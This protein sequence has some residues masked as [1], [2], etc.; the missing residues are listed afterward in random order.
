[1]AKEKIPLVSV[2]IPMYNAERFISQT[3]ESLLYQ[4]MKDFEVVVVDDCSTDNSIA[5]VESFKPRF[6]SGGGVIKN[7]MSSNS[8]RTRV[9]LTCRAM[10]VYN[11][12]AE[13]IL[14]SSIT[15]TSSPEPP[16]RN[17][18][19]S[20]KNIKLM[21]SICTMFLLL[22][23]GKKILNPFSLSQIKESIIFTNQRD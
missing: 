16:S 13:N 9:C 4:T 23:T 1:M 6:D 14:P 11:S 3:L 20:P 5:V 15:M 10:S 12:L 21:L 18:R 2:I 19:L 22:K 7:F 8:G 17:L